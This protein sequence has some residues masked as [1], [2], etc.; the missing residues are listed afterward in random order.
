MRAIS[1]SIFMLLSAALFKVDS[2]KV[3]CRDRFLEPF[4]NTSIWNTAIGSK[5]RFVPADLFVTSDLFPSQFDNDQEFFVRVS[6]SDTEFNW[7]DQGD[8]GADKKLW[9]Q[10]R[11]TPRTPVDT[12]FAGVRR[13]ERG[14]CDVVVT[15]SETGCLTPTHHRITS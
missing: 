15:E 3:Q 13:R 9:I 4:S 2:T 10:D 1:I 7:I 8:W 12:R 5:A 6:D 11:L 14:M